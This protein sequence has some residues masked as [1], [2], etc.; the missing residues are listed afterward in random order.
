[1]LLRI[2]SCLNN[3]VNDK[4]SSENLSEESVSSSTQNQAK[5]EDPSNAL[6]QA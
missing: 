3:V 2:G 6:R 1:V 5:F 4:E